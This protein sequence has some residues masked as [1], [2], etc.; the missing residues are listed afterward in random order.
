MTMFASASCSLSRWAVVVVVIVAGEWAPGLVLG[1]EL[2]PVPGL[3]VPTLDSLPGSARC[4]W[5]YGPDGP[6]PLAVVLAASAVFGAVV[7][8]VSDAEL[9]GRRGRRTCF[10]FAKIWN[11]P[12]NALALWWSRR[13][14][15]KSCIRLS[16]AA[17]TVEATVGSPAWPNEIT[18]GP[19]WLDP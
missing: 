9:E 16:V 13:F 10:D 2:A 4:T 6:T 8:A 7:D 3:S 15:Y 14:T 19:C 17:D 12:R 5:L 1:L 11:M 18:S